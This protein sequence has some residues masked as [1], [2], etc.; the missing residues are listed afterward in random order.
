MPRLLHDVWVAPPSWQLGGRWWLADVPP[1]VL[2]M[3]LVLVGQSCSLLRVV[4]RWGAAHGVFEGYSLPAERVCVAR[5]R[6]ARRR[7]PIGGSGES[8]T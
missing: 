3:A 4:L 2:P 6:D 5:V 8:P 7:N 1:P